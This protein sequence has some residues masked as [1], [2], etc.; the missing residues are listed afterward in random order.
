M[1]TLLSQLEFV[2][3]LTYPIKGRV[4]RDEMVT[5]VIDIKPVNSGIFVL[6]DPFAYSGGDEGAREDMNNKKSNVSRIL[7]NI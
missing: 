2:F 6:T 5:G 1:Y 7:R 3:Q 4:V